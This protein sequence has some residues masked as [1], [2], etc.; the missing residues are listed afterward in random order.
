MDADSGKE[1]G[2]IPDTPGVHGIALA[3]DSRTGYTSNGRDGTVTVFDPRTLKQLTHITVGTNPDAILYEPTTKRVFTFNGGSRNASVIDAQAGKV[4]QTI[5]LEGKPEFAVAD[6]RGRIYLNLEDKSEVLQIDAKRLSIEARWPLGQCQSPTGIAMDVERRRLFVGCLNRLM[7]VVDADRGNVIKTLPIGDGCD[8]TAF[9]PK[10]GLAFSSN[11]DGTLTVVREDGPDRFS[12]VEN[13]A[14]KPGARTMALDSARQR[15]YL[16]TAE[17]GPR[18]AAT[19]AQP[20][21]RPAIL[22]GSFTLLT[23]TR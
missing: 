21:P 12:V 17:F 18:P 22:P 10:A 1:I 4:V 2:T 6:G 13:V 23:L 9:D 20:N 14:T 8:A 16:V 19:A 7:A 3:P 11:G 5:A 15:I